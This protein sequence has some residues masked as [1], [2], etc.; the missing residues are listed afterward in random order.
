MTKRTYERQVVEEIRK[1]FISEL[2]EIN[3]IILDFE[4]EIQAII[5]GI[6]S[7]ELTFSIEELL[8]IRLL[9][10][11]GQILNDITERLVQTQSKKYLLGELGQGEQS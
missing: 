2:K 11:R 1:Q 10:R 7:G 3:Q 9:G 6:D 5:E 4:I 8:D